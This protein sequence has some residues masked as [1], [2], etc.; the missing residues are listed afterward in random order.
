MAAKAL[1]AK[2]LKRVRELTSALP[3]VTEQIS[4]GH[5]T[6]WVKKKVFAY[7]LDNH[8][9]D[10]RLALWCIASPG[11]Q[12][13]LVDSNPDHY[14]VPPYVGKSGWVGVRLDQDNAW[15]QISAVL[16]SAYETRAAKKPAKKR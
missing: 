6:F 16:E 9:N 5:P 1:V 10:G 8:H 2:Q 12:Q 13:M 15:P 4:H 7:F 14:F 11:A 3:D